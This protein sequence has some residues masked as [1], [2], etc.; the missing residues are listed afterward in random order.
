MIFRFMEKLIKLDKIIEIFFNR[1]LLIYFFSF[2]MG[3]NFIE[4]YL[5]NTQN[6]IKFN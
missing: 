4:K 5:N 1:K 2:K 6:L 3:N